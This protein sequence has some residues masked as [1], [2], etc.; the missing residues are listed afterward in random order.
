MDGMASAAE[1]TGATN[2]E[3]G[4]TVGAL[5]PAVLLFVNGSGRL[6]GYWAT[7]RHDFDVYTNTM[8]AA[9]ANVSGF[10]LSDAYFVNNWPG[11]PYTAHKANGDGQYLYVTQV[12][13]ITGYICAARL[14]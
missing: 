1:D 4:S 6:A 11:T 14:H 13:Y 8:G 10:N 7:A 3:Y 2:E 9:I 5:F 12:N